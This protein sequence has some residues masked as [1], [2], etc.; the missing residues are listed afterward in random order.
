MVHSRN[1][2]LPFLVEQGKPFAL[3]RIQSGSERGL[4][5]TAPGM[6]LVIRHVQPP[7]VGEGFAR[8]L[9]FIAYGVGIVSLDRRDQLRQP[10]KGAD[11]VHANS[12]IPGKHFSDSGDCRLVICADKVA[13]GFI[14]NAKSEEANETDGQQSGEKKEKP[15]NGHPSRLHEGIPRMLP[16][17]TTSIASRHT[18]SSNSFE[19][20]NSFT[21][22][23]SSSN[24]WGGRNSSFRRTLSR[25]RSCPNSS[26]SSPITS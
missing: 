10:R 17:R 24:N 5:I 13:H 22:S 6:A 1:D 2:R 18:S 25:S 20:E 16:V 8:Q 11:Q 15:F 21:S 7:D 19:T 4:G 9:Q 3:L 12:K 14:G 23:N 26:C